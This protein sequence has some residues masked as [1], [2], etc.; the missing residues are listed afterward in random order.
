MAAQKTAIYLPVELPDLLESNSKTSM[1][2]HMAV[3]YAR[4]L[5]A[6]IWDSEQLDFREVHDD[7]QSRELHMLK[8]LIKVNLLA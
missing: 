4:P 5:T 2:Q 8:A 6:S 7:G 1:V 3:L